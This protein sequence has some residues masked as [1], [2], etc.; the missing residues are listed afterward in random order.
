MHNTYSATCSGRLLV[1]ALFCLE[2]LCMIMA[3]TSVKTRAT[4][5][6]L[7]SECGMPSRDI[8]SKVKVSQMTVLRVIKRFEDT[9]SMS[10]KRK[11]KCGRKRKTS[12]RE[13]AFLLRQS[14]FDP[15]KTS[16]DL[17]KDLAAVGV[18]IST[19]LVRYRLLEAG[20]KARR[21][22]KK[23]LLTEKMRQKRL[24]WSRKYKDWSVEDWKKVTFSDESHFLVQG[25][26]SRYVRRST[27][28]KLQK[29]HIV[30]SVKHPHK[31]MFWGCFSFY[32]VGKLVPV[33][34]MMNADKYCN[35]IKSTVVKEKIAIAKDC[36]CD[37]KR[38]IAPHS[39]SLLR[40]L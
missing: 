12:K 27:G 1:C 40:A 18:D 28:E 13:D 23:Q 8:A 19:S 25:R 36:N 10:P 34:G 17:R 3:D 16:V 14:K 24:A 32:G 2:R 6:A 31:K 26:Q 7:H 35:L 22:A 20:R 33:S 38:R 39:P 30:E 21:P 11:G 37:C 29:G 4:I 15:K 9:G 5:L